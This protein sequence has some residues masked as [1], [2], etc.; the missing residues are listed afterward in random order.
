MNTRHVK[1]LFFFFLLLPCS[2]NNIM[3]KIYSY[4]A[5]N[6]ELATGYMG[7]EG[8]VGAAPLKPSTHVALALK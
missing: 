8:G 4:T 5:Q 6:L 3:E 1:G 2:F 7:V